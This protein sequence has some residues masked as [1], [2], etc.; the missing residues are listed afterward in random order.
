MLRFCL[1]CRAL[2]VD[3]R[4]VMQCNC[5][6][7]AVTVAAGSIQCVHKTGDWTASHEVVNTSAIKASFAGLLQLSPFVC[8]SALRCSAAVWLCWPLLWWSLAAPINGGSQLTPVMSVRGQEARVATCHSTEVRGGGGV[9][10]ESTA[11]WAPV[12]RGWRVAAPCPA[13]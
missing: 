3:C 5:D 7:L 6:L 4:Q 1:G 8:V 13:E 10:N 12:F 11:W 2:N 9:M